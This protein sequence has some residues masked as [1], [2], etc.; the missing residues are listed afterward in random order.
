ME[1][2]L[3][4]WCPKCSKQFRNFEPTE[5]QKEAIENPKYNSYE[6]IVDIV[7]CYNCIDERR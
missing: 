5:K 2:T 4:M 1:R 7:I 3:I 6:V